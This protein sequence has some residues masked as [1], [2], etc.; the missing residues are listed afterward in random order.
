MDFFRFWNLIDFYTGMIFETTA[1]A[2]RFNG[3]YEQVPASEGT[4]E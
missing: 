1:I 3:F 4:A 2:I